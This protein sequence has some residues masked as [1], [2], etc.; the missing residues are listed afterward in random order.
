MASPGAPP[1]TP[2]GHTAESSTGAGS[3]QLASRTAAQVGCRQAPR[4]PPTLMLGSAPDSSSSST[5]PSS[6]SEQAMSSSRS[7][8][9]VPAAEAG[10]QA[11]PGGQM[12]FGAEARRRLPS[13]LP[14]QAVA[15]PIF[16]RSGGPGWQPRLACGCHLPGSSLASMASQRS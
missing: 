10:G 6:F 7:T 11:C 16:R 2:S 15:H 13:L 9:A 1:N 8:G 5:L 14:R 12:A 4:A 3:G